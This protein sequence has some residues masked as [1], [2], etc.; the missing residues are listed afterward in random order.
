MRYARVVAITGGLLLWLASVPLR[1]QGPLLGYY[2]QRGT[3]L[4]WAECRLESRAGSI[5]RIPFLPV[6]MTG[7]VRAPLGTDDYSRDV[8][9]AA[10]LVFAGNGI[11]L[12]GVADCY[13]GR[14]S[15]WTEGPIDLKGKAVLFSFDF[16]DAIQEKAGKDFPLRRRIEE[17]ARRGASAVVL[18]TAKDDYPFP[19]VSYAPGVAAPAIPAIAVTRAGAAAI[20]EAAGL[21]SAELFASWTGAGTPPQSRDLIVRLRLRFEGAFQKS[22]TP[23]FRF[24]YRAKELDRA[25]MDR[26]AEVN[27]RALAR[28]LDLFKGAG[29]LKWVKLPT[30]YF[31]DY[32]SKLFYTHHWGSGLASDEGVFMVHKGGVPNLGLAAHENAHILATR[33]W[34]GTTSF[35]N[36]GFGRYAESLVA[37]SD[38]NDRLAREYLSQ[39]RLLPL[40]DLLGH[41]IGRPG[42]KTEVGYPAAGSFVGYLIRTYGLAAFKEAWRLE[43]REDADKAKADTW[44]S[45]FGKTLGEL[46]AAWRKSLVRSYIQT[47]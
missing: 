44:T 4:G 27:E 28:L 36:E 20:L 8:D 21:D 32:D 40:V 43:A 23:H 14:R 7:A 5:L 39:G 11:A 12:E 13:L 47:Q 41:N 15:D 17:A 1:G 38:L 29:D 6:V 25:E 34:G 19:T 42:L 31:A 10:P 24:R 46:E 18:F 16:P 33:N 3:E 22:E 26:I 45:A 37:D 9:V 35:M 30:V 2:F